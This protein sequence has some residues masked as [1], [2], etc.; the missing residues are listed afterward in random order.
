M[1]IGLVFK[2]LKTR[3]LLLDT[4]CYYFK[5]IFIEFSRAFV[6]LVSSSGSEKILNNLDKI[7][8]KNKILF[9]FFLK[10]NKTNN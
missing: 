4:H 6:T 1:E 7:K 2:S 10:T 3:N 5:K 8:L 9:Q